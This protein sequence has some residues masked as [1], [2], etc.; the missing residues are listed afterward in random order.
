MVYA[1]SIWGYA[2]EA[3]LLKLQSLQNRVLRAIG[4]FDRRIPVRV[5]HMALKI[6][7]L[8]D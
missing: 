1:C 5:M 6:P 8:Y 7:Y 4:S 2:T 3:H